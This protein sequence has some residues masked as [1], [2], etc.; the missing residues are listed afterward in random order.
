MY[1]LVYYIVVVVIRPVVLRLSPPHWILMTWVGRVLIL[2]LE[3]DLNFIIERL[4]VG[5]CG[6]LTLRLCVADHPWLGLI[7]DLEWVGK[8]FFIKKIADN[9]EVLPGNTFVLDELLTAQF[10]ESVTDSEETFQLVWFLNSRDQRQISEVTFQNLTAVLGRL[11]GVCWRLVRELVTCLWESNGWV[12]IDEWFVQ[13]AECFVLL[14]GRPRLVIKINQ[15]HELCIRS[16]VRLLLNHL[17]WGN[18]NFQGYLEKVWPW[19]FL[20]GI[21]R[22]N[23][24]SELFTQKENLTELTLHRLSMLKHFDLLFLRIISLLKIA[25]SFLNLRYCVLKLLITAAEVLLVICALC[26]LKGWHEHLLHTLFKVL[27]LFAWI[28]LP[29]LLHFQLDVLGGGHIFCLMQESLFVISLELFNY[30]LMFLSQFLRSSILIIRL[31]QLQL[32]L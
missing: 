30:K 27:L 7:L 22:L 2:G 32:Q 14:V 24:I 19:C 11:D 23:V 8:A 18:R 9:L 12:L 3:W 4:E 13:H 28:L 20:I 31:F 1:L 26:L 25:I 17:T 5:S 29:F 21:A 6:V 10:R 16:L 15:N